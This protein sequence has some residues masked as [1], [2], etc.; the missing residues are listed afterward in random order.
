MSMAL[1]FS[2]LLQSSVGFDRLLNGL[3]TAS[4][5]TPTDNW[6]PYDIVKAGEDDYRI[7]M[8]VAGFA[9]DA[10][11]ITQSRTCSWLR[12]R[13]RPRLRGTG[14]ISITV[15]PAVLSSAVSNSLT[16]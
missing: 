9:Q 2:P 15:L 11:T 13:R 12:A 4:R 3:Q 7:I 8:A 1:D 5:F 10:L 16:M 14:G 6:P